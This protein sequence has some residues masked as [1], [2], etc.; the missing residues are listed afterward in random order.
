[1]C[2]LCVT[3]YVLRFLWLG[4]ENQMIRPHKTWNKEKTPEEEIW[5]VRVLLLHICVHASLCCKC[6]WMW[7]SVHL[8]TRV[9]TF[10]SECECI[11]MNAVLR[12]D[13][14]ITSGKLASNIYRNSEPTCTTVVKQHIMKSLTSKALS[15]ICNMPKCIFECWRMRVRLCVYIWWDS[16]SAL[17]PVDRWHWRRGV[18][19]WQQ[20]GG[21]QHGREEPGLLWP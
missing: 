9:C 12:D 17:W 16:S 13:C 7:K 3:T 2:A 21:K 1:M 6:M 19:L 8:G 20:W 10:V 5:L 4:V 15:V 18:R 11:S 14:H